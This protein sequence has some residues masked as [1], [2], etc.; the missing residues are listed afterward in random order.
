MIFGQKWVKI[1]IVPSI[2]LKFDDVTMTLSLIVLSQF[3]YKLTLI[4][5][6]FMPKF[7]KIKLHLHGQK[8]RSTF[9]QWWVDGRSDQKICS[10]TD[11]PRM[12]LQVKV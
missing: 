9:A 12:I 7:V 11:V 10:R 4:I 5:S 6:Y 1:L 3:F 2:R 8:N